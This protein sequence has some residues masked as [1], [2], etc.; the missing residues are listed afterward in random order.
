M[1]FSIND[2]WSEQ[3]SIAIHCSVCPR[4]SCVLL[5]R[6][7]PPVRGHPR[8]EISEDALET[9]AAG[10]AQETSRIEERH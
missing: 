7:R 3:M 4:S 1:M 8:M 5:L 6:V 10:L 2:H 9:L